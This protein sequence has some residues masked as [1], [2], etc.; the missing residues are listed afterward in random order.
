[1]NRFAALFAALTVPALA[2]GVDEET[3]QAMVNASVPDYIFLGAEHMLTGYDHLL[4]LFG[5]LFFLTKAKDIFAFITVFTLG[6][7]LTLISATL[8]GVTANYYLV[9]AVIALSVI[10]KGFENLDGFQKFL[11]MK[12]PNLRVVVFFF[13]LIHGFGLS[14]RLQQ[15]PISDR[16][17]PKMLAF[18][19]GV[20]FGQVAALLFMMLLLKPWRRDSVGF[21]RFSRISNFGLVIIGSLLFLM[22]MHSFTHTAHSEDYGF[23]IHTHE[24]LHED[25]PLETPG[26]HD[27]LPPP[28]HTHQDS[29]DE[30][31]PVDA[32]ITVPLEDSLNQGEDAQG[33]SHGDGDH[34]HH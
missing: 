28:E 12:S 19:L 6:H 21:R 23:P 7:C 17:V 10:Y 26:H 30:N 25:L 1:M 32:E 3:Q 2:H 22:Q 29:V 9:D 34:H 16:L 8:A 5:V 31:L 20:E 33:H 11:E 14:T 24:H 27:Q 4:F 13:G 18:N 15:L